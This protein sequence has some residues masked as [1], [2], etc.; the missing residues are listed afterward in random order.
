MKVRQ[1]PTVGTIHFSH[2]L[3]TIDDFDETI[4]D[5]AL[6]SIASSLKAISLKPV[7]FEEFCVA[8][9][10]LFSADDYLDLGNSR[11]MKEINSLLTN[12]EMTKLLS[13]LL[14][15]LSTKSLSLC[16]FRLFYINKPE[17][18]KAIS[19]KVTKEELDDAIEDGYGVKYS[20]DRKKLLKAPYG[21]SGSY[22]ISKGTV[23]VC[24]SA[25]SS[26]ESLESIEIPNSVTSIGNG[27]FCIYVS[28]II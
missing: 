12:N 28:V 11:I 2:P 26:C 25:F 3:R 15:S 23:V 14:I 22:V 21:L 17:E 20:K 5:V 1:S 4:D 9:R 6:A 10:L 27:T 19:T 7:L 24:D 16:S 18:V 8:D 13:L